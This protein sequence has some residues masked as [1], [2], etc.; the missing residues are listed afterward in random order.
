MKNKEWAKNWK[1]GL[2]EIIKKHKK[3]KDDHWITKN[4]A[5]GMLLEADNI[6]TT[7]LEGTE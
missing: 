2:E 6:I 4:E 3:N 5:I 1:K 7:E